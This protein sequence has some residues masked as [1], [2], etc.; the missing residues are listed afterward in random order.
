MLDIN[1][2]PLSKN[3]RI[4]VVLNKLAASYL[5]KPKSVYNFLFFNRVKLFPGV[6]IL[7]TSMY[8]SCAFQ[9]LSEQLL[10]PA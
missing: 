6:A 3:D 2:T 7:C 9:I 10:R 8:S 1:F 4:F 5:E